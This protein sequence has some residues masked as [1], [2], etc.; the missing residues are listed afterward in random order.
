MTDFAP[1]PITAEDV[2]TLDRT[3]S[4]TAPSARSTSWRD[5]RS[6]LRDNDRQLVDEHCCP[7]ASALPDR[8]GELLPDERRRR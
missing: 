5:R 2:E 1:E 3:A 6:D 8:L 7:S 4:C